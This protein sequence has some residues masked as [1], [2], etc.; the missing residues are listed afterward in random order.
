M[1]N[2]CD[3]RGYF[4]LIMCDGIGRKPGSEVD[5]K[6]PSAVAPITRKWKPGT[7][8]EYPHKNKG[9]KSTKRIPEA[10]EQDEIQ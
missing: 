6:L 10:E 3:K 5:S 2:D 7:A 1:P 9:R 4:D 8:R